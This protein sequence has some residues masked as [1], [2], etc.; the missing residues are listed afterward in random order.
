[1]ANFS[2]NGL[3]ITPTEILST[4]FEPHETICFRVFADRKDEIFCGGY[5]CE[6]TLANVAGT[7]ENLKQ[8]NDRHRG[9]FY[10]VNHGGHEDS[11]ITRINAQFVEMDDVSLE[12]QL[13]RVEAFPL[14]PSLII[15]TRKSLHVYWFVKNGEVERFRHIQK[16]LVKQFNGDSACVNESRVLRLPGFYH[17][18]QEPIMVEVVKYNPELKYSQEQLS[19]FLPKITEDTPVNVR[20]SHDNRGNQ[21]G[22]EVIAKCPFFLHCK[23]NAATLPEPLWYAMITNL[24]VF[25][26]GV[27]QIHKLSSLYPNYSF[28]ETQAKIDHFFK[29][30]T[31]PMTC[32]LLAER[33]FQ[34]PKMSDCKA[35]SPAGLA[36]FSLDMKYI[37]KRLA[38]CK[39]TNV[40]IDDA[41]TAE[42][43]VTFGI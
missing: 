2:L 32:K 17:C 31:K 9:I 1:M 11:A 16:Q 19:E 23:K 38:S 40:T 34:C 7:L 20:K 37:R 21:K 26:G 12:E 8:H 42:L 6:S 18:K 35:K 36:Y 15:R 5:K 3:N 29:S 30:G 41:E 25:E 22:L 28:E 39:V 4:M 27:A 10:V 14:E 33:G 24:A 13:A 43:I